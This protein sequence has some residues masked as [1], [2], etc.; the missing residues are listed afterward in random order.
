[1]ERLFTLTV[2][3]ALGI[4]VE[5]EK[6]RGGIGW[7][8]LAVCIHNTPAFSPPFLWEDLFAWISQECSM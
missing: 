6:E 3:D 8:L 5:R 1:M 2:N 4:A 7:W